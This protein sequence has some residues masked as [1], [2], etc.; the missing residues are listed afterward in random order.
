[1]GWRGGDGVWWCD[2]ASL[3]AGPVLLRLWVI[4]A[5]SYKVVCGTD[6][7]PLRGQRLT[8]VNCS[9][10]NVPQMEIARQIAGKTQQPAII[11]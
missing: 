6:L 1:M 10:T 11:A 2:E 7:V 8:Y 4:M 3:C 5:H 9:L